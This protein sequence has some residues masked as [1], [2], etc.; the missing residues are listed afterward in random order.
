MSAPHA[1]AT[2]PEKAFVWLQRLLPTLALSSLIHRIAAIRHP[3]TK[4]W[5]IKRFLKHFPVDLSEAIWDKPENYDS[6]NAFFTRPLKPGARTLDADPMTLVSP[7]DG[8]ISQLGRIENGQIFQAKGH[9]YSAADLLG[10]EEAAAPFDGGG[11]CTIYLAPHNYHRVH[12]PATGILKSWSYVPGQLFSVNDATARLLPGL[13]TRNERVCARFDTVYGP[14]AVVLVGALLVGGIETVWSGP[15][16]PPHGGEANDYEPMN[17]TKLTRGDELG[18]FNMGS[19]VILL[20]APGKI[21]WSDEL[22]AGEAVRM[23]QALG[24]L[25]KG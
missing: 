17:T 6:F 24:R 19:T 20:S 25:A 1:D 4:N 18:R 2:L 15:V 8:R 22:D 14:L 16:T 12:M 9:V 13:F 7:A 23:G 3:A 10:S 5:L 11:F 21:R